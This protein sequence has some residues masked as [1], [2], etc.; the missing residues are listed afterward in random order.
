MREKGAF[1]FLRGIP[2][3]VQK[4]AKRHSPHGASA[5]IGVRRTQR[6]GPS[7]FPEREAG[8]E[9]ANVKLLSMG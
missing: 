4:L 6:K 5:P 7:F 1:R 8:R 3:R 9:S 2:A